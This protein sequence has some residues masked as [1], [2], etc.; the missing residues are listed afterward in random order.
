MSVADSEEVF[1][2]S[3]FPL[4]L[5]KMTASFFRRSTKMTCKMINASLKS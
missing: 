2:F 5:N 4:L 3:N 1:I